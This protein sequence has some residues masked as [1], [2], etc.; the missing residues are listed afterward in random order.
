MLSFTLTAFVELMDHG[1]V[2][3]DTFSVAFIKKIASF[4][5]KSAMD[6]SILQR[7]LA[8]LESMVL[9]SHDLYQKVAQEITI[10]QLIPHLQGCIWQ[11]AAVMPWERSHWQILEGKPDWPVWV[12]AYPRSHSQPVGLWAENFILPKAVF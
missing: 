7:S 1:I 12:G 2:S 6:V 11:P 3:W 5:N 4:V 10:G 8:I 9:N